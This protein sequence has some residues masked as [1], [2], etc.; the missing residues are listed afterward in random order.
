MREEI[1]RRLWSWNSDPVVS[2][3]WNTLPSH[4]KKVYLEEADQILAI[5]GEYEEVELPRIFVD[6]NCAVF[7]RKIKKE[8]LKLCG[9][10]IYRRVKWLK[11]RITCWQYC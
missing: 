6:A 9:G 3:K 2:P 10:K 8:I 11:Y 7:V 1:A 4:I 5:T